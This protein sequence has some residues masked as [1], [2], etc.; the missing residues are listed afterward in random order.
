MYWEDRS[1]GHGVL[2]CT[3]GVRTLLHVLQRACTTHAN[4]AKLHKRLR[5]VAAAAL[6][7]LAAL[8]M[9]SRLACMD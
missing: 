1:G 9:H 2:K 3:C 8:H 6:S 4:Y 5:V 7:A